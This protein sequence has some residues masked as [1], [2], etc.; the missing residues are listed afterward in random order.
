MVNRKTVNRFLAA[1]FLAFG[2][3]APAQAQDKPPIRILVGFPA[4]G[5][6]SNLSQLL[7]DKLREV[8]KQPVIVENRPGVGGR[9]AAEALKNASPNGYSYM[10]APNATAV[11]QHLM[12]P[13]S[14]LRYDVLKDLTPVA[15]LVS[16]PLLLAVHG[17][18]GARSVKDYVAW[19]QA[20]A[21]P[22]QFATA[23]QAG[24][25]HLT[26][27]MF[28]KAAGIRMEVV[29]YRGNGPLMTD[30]V[31]GQVPAAVVLAGD[32]MPHVRSGRI[33][34]LGIFSTQRSPLTPGVPTLA[35]QG[36]ETVRSDAWFGLWA[37]AKT[38]QAELTRMQEAVRQVLAMP[39]VRTTLE[40]KLAMSPDFKPAAE[41]DRLLRSEMDYWAAVIKDADFKAQQ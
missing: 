10:V 22:G 25:T 27:L 4:G 24:Q 3:G 14:V 1:A 5:G 7:A 18:T 32:A 15:T 6:G 12:Y 34:A 29:P 40:D 38:P 16:Y 26:G 31:G 17:Q 9:L 28:A 8:L 2:L 41:M 35:E 36:F 13:V 33:Q 30:L 20:G 21:G 19:V 23:G 11:F 37:N 39:E